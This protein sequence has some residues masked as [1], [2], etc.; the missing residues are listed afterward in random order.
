VGPSFKFPSVESL[1]PLS[2]TIVLLPPLRPRNPNVLDTPPRP[3]RLYP[4]FLDR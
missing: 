4:S 1:G 3:Q 2:Q